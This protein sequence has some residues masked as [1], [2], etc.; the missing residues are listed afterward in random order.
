MSL[1]KLVK[2]F[3]QWNRELSGYSKYKERVL[4]TQNE[5]A[6]EDVAIGLTAQHVPDQHSLEDQHESKEAT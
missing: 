2:R 1:G 6:T 3:A 4:L 5:L